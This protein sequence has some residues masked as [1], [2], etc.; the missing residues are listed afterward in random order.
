VARGRPQ[1][2]ES[3]DGCCA[4]YTHTHTHTHT[5]LLG[6]PAAEAPSQN[7]LGRQWRGYHPQVQLPRPEVQGLGRCVWDAILIDPCQDVTSA[8]EGGWALTRRWTLHR[9]LAISS[10]PHTTA[11][12]HNTHARVIPASTALSEAF[13]DDHVISLG[14]RGASPDVIT[15]SSAR[16]SA[17]EMTGVRSPLR[18]L[19]ADSKLIW[20]A[21]VVGD[22]VGESVGGVEGAC[23][24]VRKHRAP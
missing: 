16:A 15:A 2:G 9:L 17:R 7:K 3:G 8:C 11:T 24:C 20:A 5:H 13:G 1:P 6:R 22:A 4:W 21:K 12:Q 14:D 19:N 23:V 10:Q 18:D